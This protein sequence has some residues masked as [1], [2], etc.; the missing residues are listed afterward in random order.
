MI[1]LLSAQIR[2]LDDVYRHQPSFVG[3]QARLL[4]GFNLLIL[5]FIPL[6]VGK[7]LWLQLP[8]TPTR[9]LLNAI[10]F[11]AAVMSLRWLKQG[12]LNFA[13]SGLALAL[14]LPLHA[15]L[16]FS[17]PY[18]QPLSAAIQLFAYDLVFLLLALVFASRG[19]ALLVF[20]I[21][22]GSHV[23]FYWFVLHR[24][25]LGGT[26]EFAADTLLRDGLFALCFVF[27]LGLAI[28]TMIKA[29]YARSEEALSETRRT[30]ENL[31]VLVSERTR[32]LE[33]ATLRATEASCI[34]I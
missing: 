2:K 29:A 11:S 17:A 15:L 8:S 3:V 18:P 5:V 28:A 32:D 27:S 7:L 22:L 4:G 9:L 34:H 1:R 33:R 12:R 23:G 14:M 21:I 30:N 19:V 13:G 24:L 10:M 20:A 25:S 31:E 16:F 26:L 6:N